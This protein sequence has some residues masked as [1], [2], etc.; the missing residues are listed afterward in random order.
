VDTVTGNDHHPLLLEDS[1]LHADKAEVILC[2]K[3]AWVDWDLPMFNSKRTKTVASSKSLV[4]MLGY[5]NG[6]Q[7]WNV[8]DTENVREICSVRLE[9]QSVAW[10]E[11]GGSHDF[12]KVF[13]V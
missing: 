12:K 6:F 5:A 10:I 3:F 9:Q 2:S 11:V 7:I 1:H 4:L 13:E 8:T